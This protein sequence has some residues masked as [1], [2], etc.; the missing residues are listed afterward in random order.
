MEI[1]TNNTNEL[2]ATLIVK[3]EEK[4]YTEVFE[5]ELKKMRKT[6]NVKGFRPG[7]VPMGMIKKMYGNEVKAQEVHKLLDEEIKKHLKE[8]KIEV[9]GDLLPSKKEETK[10]DIEN[11][12]DF[13]FAFDYGFFP[14]TEIKLDG[15]KVPEYNITIEDKT[16][17]DEVINI[18]EKNGDFIEI[19]KV[20]E[21]SQIRANFTELGDDK[22]AKE[23]GVSVQDGLVLIDLLDEATKKELMGAKTDS[24]FTINVKKAFTNETDLAG[25]LKIEKEK[26]AEINDNFEIVITKIEEYKKGELNQDFFDKVFG[27]DEVKSEEEMRT[28]IKELIEKQYASESTVRF[29]YDFR[30]ELKDSVELPLPDEFIIRWQLSRRDDATEEMLRKDMKSLKDAIKWDRVLALLSDEHDIKVE[31]SD[32][33]DASKAQIVNQL[34]QMGMSVEMFSEEQM[35]QF[36]EQE[37]EKMNEN[38]RYYLVFSTMERKVLDGLN[39]KVTKEAKEITFDELK[40]IYEVE[41]DKI[42]KENEARKEEAEVATV[43]NKE[44]EKSEE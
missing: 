11:S 32:L 43:E 28:K 31:Q 44:V 41:N 2:E 37:L 3:I 5:G 26:L 29:R 1:T 15:L 40:K 7:K 25:L 36:A 14:Q 30:N 16:I 39:D 27:K 19:D 21:K 17:D 20:I 4:D 22:K 6:A 18:L 35:T 9:I 10:F 8:N 13:Q 42:A 33:L 23:D 34:G 12:N 38:D 24:E